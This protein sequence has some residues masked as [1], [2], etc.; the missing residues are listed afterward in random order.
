VIEDPATR[1]D[2]N[3]QPASGVRGELDGALEG[4]DRRNAHIDEQQDLVRTT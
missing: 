2:H 4:V 1:V 3:Q